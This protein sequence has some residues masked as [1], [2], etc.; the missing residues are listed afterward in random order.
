MGRTGRRRE[1]IKEDRRGED[2]KQ[3]DM[4]K[5]CPQKCVP[6]SFPKVFY[7]VLEKKI[8]EFEGT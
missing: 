8:F 7:S 6:S 1:Q 5:L 2:R 4:S 3:R